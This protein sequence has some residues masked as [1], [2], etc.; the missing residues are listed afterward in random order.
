MQHTMSKNRMDDCGD[1]NVAA[2]VGYITI[3]PLYGPQQ[4]WSS[5][6]SLLTNT[7]SIAAT[8][9]EPIGRKELATTWWENC[10]NRCM[11]HVP[12]NKP[13]K[14]YCKSLRKHVSILSKKLITTK[15]STRKQWDNNI[16]DDSRFNSSKLVDDREMRI[17]TT[18]PIAVQKQQRKLIHITPIQ[19]STTNTRT[20]VQ[21]L[22][23]NLRIGNDSAQP[24]MQFYV[25][26]VQP[27]RMPVLQINKT[28]TGGRTTTTN[29]TTATPVKRKLEFHASNDRADDQSS[30]SQIKNK[31]SKDR[32]A[33]LD[34]KAHVL[35]HETNK[36][37]K[38]QSRFPTRTTNPETED[39]WSEHVQDIMFYHS[40]E[41]GL[42][43]ATDGPQIITTQQLIPENNTTAIAPKNALKRVPMVTPGTTLHLDSSKK[44]LKNERLTEQ[45]SS[46]RRL[47]PVEK[48]NDVFLFKKHCERIFHEECVEP[49]DVRNASRPS[50][51]IEHSLDHTD[52]CTRTNHEI[53]SLSSQ[54]EHHDNDDSD[55]EQYATYL[56]LPIPESYV[57][58]SSQ[59]N[60]TESSVAPPVYSSTNDNA[61]RRDHCLTSNEDC[62]PRTKVVDLTYHD[63][64]NMITGRHPSEHPMK[65]RFRQTMIELI[66]LNN[67][68]MESDDINSKKLWLPSLFNKDT[69]LSP[70][71]KFDKLP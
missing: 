24:W 69:V 63:W 8:Y 66:L 64:K 29:P 49:S 30:G 43:N 65:S 53:R 13:C 57:R 45:I 51:T 37:I 46:Q 52:N 19:P 15:F 10:P 41:S 5:T 55:E 6:N 3:T 38:Q 71:W 48:S 59:N 21:T 47:F 32:N 54:Q 33:T 35:Q 12:S 2:L 7:P 20:S 36:R 14:Q 62:P 70:S 68:E 9:V 44:T 23:Y 16:G 42:I 31:R 50:D 28:S 11:A 1:Q 17:L 26:I 60:D 67:K 56:S 39:W 4:P 25:S 61:M 34:D 27:P 18:H 22:C 40:E 58:S